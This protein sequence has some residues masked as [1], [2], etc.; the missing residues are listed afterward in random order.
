MV[1]HIRS[2]HEK[3]RHFICDLCGRDFKYPQDLKAH[4]RHV[5]E[6]VPRVVNEKTIIND[7]KVCGKSFNDASNFRRHM[8]TIHKV[9]GTGKAGRPSGKGNFSKH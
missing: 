6:K 7:C 9:F 8:R 5:H 1:A 2:Q 3:S 4:T